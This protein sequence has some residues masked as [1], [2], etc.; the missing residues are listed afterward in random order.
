MA[1]SHRVPSS[2][3][4]KMKRRNDSLPPAFL[5]SQTYTTFQY[6]AQPTR[7][8]A[9]TTTEKGVFL[10]DYGLLLMSAKTHRERQG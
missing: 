4:W 7:E 9:K 8:M 1:A 6:T 2:Y 5:P 10:V 3:D